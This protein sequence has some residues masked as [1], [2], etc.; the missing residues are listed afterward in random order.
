MNFNPVVC[1]I[2]AVGPENVI[3]KDNVMPWHC[4]TDLQ[5]FRKTTMGYPCIFGRKT[6]V[7]MGNKPLG[8]RI[9]VVLSS[10]YNNHWAD[11][12]LWLG[13][14]VEDA[15][16]SFNHCQKIFV[17]GGA[18]VYKY[19]FDNDL[20][21]VFYLTKIENAD[22]QSQIQQAPEKYTYFPVNIDMFFKSD[23]WAKKQIAYQNK[24]TQID[25]T[26]TKSTFW[27]YTRIR[28]KYTNPINNSK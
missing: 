20:I 25:A 13:K 5:F 22:L 18:Q 27:E 12:N 2:V 24:K 4:P 11:V 17:C 28:K 21:D 6:F 26:Q 15:I 9:N 3:G 19:A 14:S 8:G 7:G 1:A 16:M 23:K 10:Q